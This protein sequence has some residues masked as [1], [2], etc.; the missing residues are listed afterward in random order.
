MRLS[1]EVGMSR[2]GDDEE[3][4]VSWKRRVLIERQ[5][6]VVGS[7]DMLDWFGRQMQIKN[8][9]VPWYHHPPH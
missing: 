3:V 2:E 8:Q 6:K 1:R 7:F 9:S 5:K 4:G